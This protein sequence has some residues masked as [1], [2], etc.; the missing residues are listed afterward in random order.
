MKKIFRT[1]GELLVKSFREI[2][3]PLATGIWYWGVV[4]FLLLVVGGLASLPLV[5]WGAWSLG[6]LVT[7]LLAIAIVWVIAA[8]VVLVYACFWTATAMWFVGDFVGDRGSADPSLAYFLILCWFV[9]F[10]IWFMTVIP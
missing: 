10:V 5:V 7:G 2:L 8:F 6:H 4:F 1:T 3:I 9:D